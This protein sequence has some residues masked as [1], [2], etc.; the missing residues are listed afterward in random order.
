MLVSVVLFAYPDFPLP[1]F[2]QLMFSLLLL[3]PRLGL[4]LAFFKGLVN[5]LQFF[6]CLHL[7]FFRACVHF[8]L[9]GCYHLYKVGFRSWSCASAM[10]DGLFQACLK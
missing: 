10:L 8:L 1:E 5:F 2:C 7:D 4:D 9:Q 3:F 6:V